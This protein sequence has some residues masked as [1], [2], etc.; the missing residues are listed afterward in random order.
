[1]EGEHSSRVSGAAA[2]TINRSPPEYKVHILSSGTLCLRT[3]FVRASEEPED[4]V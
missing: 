3:C 1:M 4:L 2:E